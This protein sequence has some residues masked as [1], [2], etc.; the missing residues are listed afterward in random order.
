[1]ERARALHELDLRERFGRVQLPYALARKYPNANR[2]WYRQYVFPARHRSVDPRSG[3][4]QRHHIAE[5]A[6]QK[7]VE[8]A[9][10]A[11]G[12]PSPGVATPS[13]TAS[14]PT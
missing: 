11:A 8:R 1:L 4:E 5:T 6:L 12:W 9:I 10:I 2:E 14:P 13:A 3:R 7:A